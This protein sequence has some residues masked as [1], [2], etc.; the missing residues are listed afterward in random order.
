M[1]VVPKKP[2]KTFILLQR[3]TDLRVKIQFITKSVAPVI[4]SQTMVQGEQFEQ[5]VPLSSHNI[6]E[7]YYTVFFLLYNL[8]FTFC[9]S[10]R[11][12]ASATV[13]WASF[14]W[15]WHRGNI[16]SYSLRQPI[17]RGYSLRTYNTDES[18]AS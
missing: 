14:A 10:F 7:Q 5:L 1:N 18:K 6:R 8:F 2:S 16:R 4:S 3:T 12:S 9:Q 15:V 11:S 13:D 17:T